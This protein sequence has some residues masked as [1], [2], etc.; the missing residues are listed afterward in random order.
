MAN[1]LLR[2]QSPYLRQHAHNPVDWYPW[3]EEAFARARA[4][5]KPIFLS[6]GYATCHWCHVMERESFE[7]E[8]VAALLNETFVC[9]KVDREE[10]PDID[11]VYMTVCQAMTRSGG[12]PLTILMAPDQRPFFAA[13]YIPRE[14]RFGRVGMLELIPAVAEAWAT[15]RAELLA[16]G[17]QVAEALSGLDDTAAAATPDARLLGRARQQLAQ[18]F[19]ATH[20]GFGQAPK[21]PVPHQLMFLLR[22][23]DADAVRMV[24]KTLRAMRRGGIYDQVGGGFHR[25]STDAEWLVPHFEKML[26]D[27]ALLTLAYL[28]AYQLTGEAEYAAVAREVLDYVSRDMTSPEG[29][30]YSAQDADSEG[31]EGKYYV[32]SVAE[33]EAVLGSA[34]AEVAVAAW[35]ATPVGNFVE[36][37]TRHRTGTNI[38]HL[39]SD[40][41]VPD[42]RLAAFAAK[43]LAAR[44]Q[45]VPPLL[46]DKVLTDWN[47]LM[48][49]AYARAGRVLE[50][51]ACLAVARGA[52]EFLR[53]AMRTPDG[54]LW[55]RYR[56][57]EAAIPAYLDDYAFLTWGLLELYEATFETRW[58]SWAVE[59]AAQLPAHFLAPD[60]S[61]YF[62]A[63]DAEAL[64]TRSREWHDGALPSGNAVT[65][66]NLLRLASLTGDVSYEQA[67]ERLLAAAGGRLAQAPL[68]H[69][70]LLTGLDLALGPR[71]DLV[72]VGDPGAP[73]TDALLAV[74]RAG[75]R[76]R[77]SVLLKSPAEA[78]ALAALAPHTAALPF[79][80]E[81]AT[82]YLCRD[83]ACGLPLAS[84]EAL[85]GALD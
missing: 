18:G 16:V 51:Q 21:F 17:G 39:A 72:I 53:T 50:D 46:D 74:A 54:R 44:Q 78:D 56:G 70:H 36:E 57:G 67:A 22:R 71:Q 42:D 48:I 31:E 8:A 32:W 23:G 28:E 43:L 75:F 19:D 12:W 26:Y 24:G 62:T 81:S 25:Y 14:N 73:E 61:Y 1:R 60:G 37:A 58:L 4:E 47:G 35:Q 27:Q 11:Q 84:P 69:T 6:I 10:R 80:A 29:G 15:R 79:P 13:T 64:L 5:D 41:P 40:A 2:E 66:S 77:L 83:G 7:D 85:A 3:G 38:L 20:G 65:L 59:L 9:V 30:F 52:A 33:L 34:E 49:A 63:D 82:A 76:P 68:A 55:H 45:R